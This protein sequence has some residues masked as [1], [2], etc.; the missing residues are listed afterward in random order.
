MDVSQFGFDLNTIYELSKRFIWNDGSLFELIHNLSKLELDSNLIAND[1]LQITPT[2]IRALLDSAKVVNGSLPQD[3]NA[4]ER[5]TLLMLIIEFMNKN[6]GILDKLVSKI[7]KETLRRRST[8]SGSK[9]HT[10]SSNQAGS[11]LEAYTQ[12]LEFTLEHSMSRFMKVVHEVPDFLARE[13]KSTLYR[14]Y[15]G[16]ELDKLISGNYFELIEQLSIIAICCTA[17]QEDCYSVIVREEHLKVYTRLCSYFRS[18]E[19]DQNMAIQGRKRR[20]SFWKEQS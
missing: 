5:T 12:S 4:R 18:K 9:T 20:F 13:L 8:R 10:V 2:V 17:P 11:L 3:L 14:L 1:E 6:T 19:R 16:N 7:C 15:R